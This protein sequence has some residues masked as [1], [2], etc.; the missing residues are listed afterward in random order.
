[1]EFWV[2]S[3]LFS[4]QSDLRQSYSPLRDLMGRMQIPWTTRSSYIPK[5]Q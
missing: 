3:Q 1:M 5:S 4:P 2:G